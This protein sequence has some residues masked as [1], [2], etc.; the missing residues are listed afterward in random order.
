T[1][2]ARGGGGRSTGGC[3][4]GGGGRSTGGTSSEAPS[5][6]EVQGGGGGNAGGGGG[7]GPGA[8][9]RDGQ[10]GRGAARWNA[11]APAGRLDGLRPE[12]VR[13]G[14]PR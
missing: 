2:S 3:A 9:H 11:A 1:G 5:V 10:H 14:V 12:R 8:D 6:G 13:P 4:R 7:S